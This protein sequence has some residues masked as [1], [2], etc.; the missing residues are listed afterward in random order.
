MADYVSFFIPA[1]QATNGLGASYGF[2]QVK[3]PVLTE[4]SRAQITVSDAAAA[5][6]A[7]GTIID[8]IASMGPVGWI[9]IVGV[10]A[11]AGY[12]GIKAL[13]R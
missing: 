7:K 10:A 8:R 5:A 9:A 2:S 3:K 11:T 13:K 1:K 6:A 4:V 12:Y